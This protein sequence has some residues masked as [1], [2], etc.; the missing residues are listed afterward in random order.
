MERLKKCSRCGDDKPL[1]EFDKRTK[2]S[3]GYSS[4]CKECQ[5]KRLIKERYGL[6]YNEYDKL[7]QEQGGFCLV[8]EQPAKLF[9]DHCH[10]SLAVRGLLC[11]S[12]NTIL[13]H[14]NDNVEILKN[15][16]EYLENRNGR[17]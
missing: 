9:V 10:N 15:A 12:C 14:A 8:C 4:H 5:K 7:T 17:N 6:S 11:N 16:I 3:D 13:G 2:S 1:S